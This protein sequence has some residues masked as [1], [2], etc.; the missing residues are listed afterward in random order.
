MSSNNHH[1]RPRSQGGT[2]N[3]P[4]NNKVRV[5]EGK[6]YF[7]HCLFGNKTGEEI[8]RELNSMWLD[9]VYRVVIVKKTVR[10]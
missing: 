3:K 1:R 7:W 2:T 5:D 8:A 6:H 10:G 9:P 4:K